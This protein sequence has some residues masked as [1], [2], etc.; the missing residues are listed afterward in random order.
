ME[1]AAL[2]LLIIVSTFLAIFL[3]VAII[4]MLLAIKLIAQLKLVADRAESAVDTV[5]AAGVML[6]NAS[7]PLA[8]IKVVASLVRK[9]SKNRK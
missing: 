7:G 9:Y 6:R 5:A 1:T 2:V 3:L 4:L 8:M